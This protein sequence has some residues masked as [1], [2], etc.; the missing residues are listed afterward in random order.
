MNTTHTFAGRDFERL[1]TVELERGDDGEIRTFM[2]Q[3]NYRDASAAA[4][5]VVRRDRA[6]EA[7]GRVLINRHCPA[8]A[9]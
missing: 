9:G 8:I 2:P 6:P 5:H 3:A 4:L 1:G 7:L